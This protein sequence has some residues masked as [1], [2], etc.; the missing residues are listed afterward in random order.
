MKTVKSI[1]QFIDNKLLMQFVGRQ[2]E[3]ARFD[4]LLE[5]PYF[6]AVLLTGAPGIG[7]SYPIRNHQNLKTQTPS[8]KCSGRL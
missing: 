3:L 8:K 7:K 6:S 4:E 5:K 2:E 1:D